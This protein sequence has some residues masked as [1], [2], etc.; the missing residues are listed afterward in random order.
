MKN[1]ILFCFASIFAGF[2]CSAPEK[3]SE[4]SKIPELSLEIIDSLDLKVLGDPLITSVSESGDSF[5]FYNYAFSDIIITNS[6][7]EIQSQFNK[8]EDIPDSY[9]IMLESPG[10]IG[11]D[12]LVIVG[13]TGIFI[14]DLEG[15]LVKKIDHPESL[16]GGGSMVFPGKSVE[17]I[18]LN[19]KTYL[20]T[21]SL[22]TRDSYPG[23]QKYYDTFRHFEL[24]DIATGSSNEIVPFEQNS[25]F[26]DGMG[27]YESDFWPALEAKNNKLYVALAGEPTLYRYSLNPEGAALDTLVNL[28]IPGFAGIDGTPR[29]EFAEGI[30]MLN[31]STST[32]Q[33]IHI[34]DDK[35]IINYYGGISTE[36]NAELSKL[37]ETNKMEEAEEMYFRLDSQVSRGILVFDLENLAYLGNLSLPKNADLE[38]FAS[39]GGYLWMQKNPSEEVEE[40]FLRIYKVKLTGK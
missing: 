13:T 38:S 27:Y 23:E 6:E 5:L 24:V 29:V 10:F 34:V 33:N 25:R 3:S 4:D 16:G 8:S 7:G 21:R 12:Q 18:V 36:D 20:V 37:Y 19:G 9:Q 35:L 14:Y 17:T 11:N 31:G 28:T 22:R 32:I 40:D 39:G 30:V 26:L 15:N 2:A 1:C